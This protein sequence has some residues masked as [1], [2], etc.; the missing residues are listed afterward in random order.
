M[1]AFRRVV[2]AFCGFNLLYVGVAP[3]LHS[4]LRR[5]ATGEHFAGNL[6]LLE[7][8]KTTVIFLFFV[9]Q[10]HKKKKFSGRQRYVRL[11]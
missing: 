4:I 6:V 9:L 10:S 8:K 5:L 11:Y 1:I 2:I 7:R 3:N